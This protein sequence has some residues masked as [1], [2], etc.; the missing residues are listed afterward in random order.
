MDYARSTRAGFFFA[1]R[2]QRFRRARLSRN[3]FGAGRRIAYAEIVVRV[4]HEA[5][6]RGKKRGWPEGTPPVFGPALT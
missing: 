2:F 3:K 1:R 4:E 5:T 6:K